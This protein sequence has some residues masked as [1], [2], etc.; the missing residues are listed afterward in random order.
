[1]VA[2]D[3]AQLAA[4]RRLSAAELAGVGRDVARALAE[5][6]Q[7]GVVHRYLSPQHVVFQA[8]GRAQVVGFGL[9]MA[10]DGR[11][12][13]AIAPEVAGDG[14]ST[15]ATDV[16]ALGTLLAGMGA[17]GDRELAR[18]VQA[19]TAE[20]L[21]ERPSA[22][23][24]AE[25]FE[26][27]VQARV[28]GSAKPRPWRYVLAGVACFVA[29]GLLALVALGPQP[30]PMRLEPMHLELKRPMTKLEIVPVDQGP[31]RTA[32]ADR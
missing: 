3:L 15:S 23:E 6:H 19:C 26:R 24:L 4:H 31:A 12:R 11:H 7:C 14:W 28:A 20:D 13:G 30:E 21:T 9:P 8:N 1:V 17:E 29:G 16:F 27:I 2:C 22:D 25:R 5:A 10:A 18:V 32:A